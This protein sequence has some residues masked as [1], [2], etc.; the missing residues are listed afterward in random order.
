MQ[1]VVQVNLRQGGRIFS[2]YNARSPLSANNRSPLFAMQTV[3]HWWDSYGPHSDWFCVLNGVPFMRYEHPLN[4]GETEL[5]FPF[6]NDGNLVTA[7]AETKSKTRSAL[8]L[9]PDRATITGYSLNWDAELR[10]INNALNAPA[11]VVSLNRDFGTD[12]PSRGQTFV[13]VRDGDGDGD[14]EIVLFYVTLKATRQEV[15]NILTNEFKVADALQLDGGESSQLRCVIENVNISGKD[16][17]FFARPVP[18]VFLLL[19]AR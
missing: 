18:H 14:N 2:L 13:A 10:L 3:A 16:L 11:A 5:S 15:N 7:G 12:D 8:L 19:Q 4:G 6:R 17:G 9:Y 1:Y